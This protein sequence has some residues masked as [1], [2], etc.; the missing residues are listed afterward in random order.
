MASVDM[1]LCRLSVRKFLL[2]LVLFY[3]VMVWLFYRELMTFSTRVV[4]RVRRSGVDYRDVPPL[5]THAATTSAPTTSRAPVVF[6]RNHGIVFAVGDDT[7][8]APTDDFVEV[9]PAYGPCDGFYESFIDVGPY[10]YVYSVYWDPRLNDLDNLDSE[11]FL[12]IMVVAD[13]MRAEKNA[14][15]YCVFKSSTGEDLFEQ[16]SFY[17]LVENRSG[18]WGGYMLSCRV[19]KVVYGADRLK[20]HCN[21]RLSPTFNPIVWQRFAITNTVP[22]TSSRQREFTVCVPPLSG[23][24]GK[25]NI[26]GFME[27][28]RLLGASHVMFYDYDLSSHARLLVQYYVKN[29]RATLLPWKLIDTPLETSDYDD[30]VEAIAMMDCLYRNMATS[31][32]VVFMDLDEYIVPYMQTSWRAMLDYLDN[33]KRSGFEFDRVFFDRYTQDLLPNV[34]Y[35]KLRTLTFTWRSLRTNKVRTRCIVKPQLVLEV[36]A[37]YVSR[38]VFLRYQASR[39]TYPVALLHCHGVCQPGRDDDCEYVVQDTVLPRRYPLI[40]RRLHKR[41]SAQFAKYHDEIYYQ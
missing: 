16:T 8:S 1:W 28:T 22:V 10:V 13:N 9:P 40:L 2:I 18:N 24:I 33:D 27:L 4:E 12:R 17:R 5:L 37:H 7:D 41:Q 3:L 36:G 35:S 19:P 21:V 32:Y 14:P 11:V 23:E 38:A 39:V 20:A 29:N 26:I 6:V 31:K 30:H 34:K 25:S 15:L